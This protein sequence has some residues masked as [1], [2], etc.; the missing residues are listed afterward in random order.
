MHGIFGAPQA[1]SWGQ[2]S[3]FSKIFSLFKFCTNFL[4]PV[5]PDFTD[6]FGF[7]KI[8]KKNKFYK[9]FLGLCL[10]KILQ[11]SQKKQ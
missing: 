4:F 8:L 6:T 7:Y 2:K 1:A 11:I 10:E 5:S 9:F 3:D